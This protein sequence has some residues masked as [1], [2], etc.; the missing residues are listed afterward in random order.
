MLSTKIA[1]S[2]QLDGALHLRGKIQR[3]TKRNCQCQVW[4]LFRPVQ[5]TRFK[6]WIEI[7]RAIVGFL[8]PSV[9]SFSFFSTKSLVSI[10][11]LFFLMIQFSLYLIV[12]RERWAFRC[13]IFW[14]CL[15]IPLSVRFSHC[16]YLLLL[17]TKSLNYLLR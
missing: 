17:V 13:K 15:Q 6:S 7:L 5:I 8:L 11:Y 9:I 1:R 2:F 4:C 12:F 3:T 16:L 14:V 10:I